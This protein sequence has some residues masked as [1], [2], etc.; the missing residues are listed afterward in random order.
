MVANLTEKEAIN[1]INSLEGKKLDFDGWYGYQCFDLAN[2][3]FNKLF[4]GRLAGF[5]AKNIPTANDFSGKAVVYNNTE[6]FV[7]KPGDIVVFNGNYGGGHG[8]VAIVTNGNADGNLINFVSLDQNWE[9]GGWTSG[10]EQG[11]TG[12]EPA[13]KVTHAYD[14]PMWFIRPKFKA[15]SKSSTQS[16]SKSKSSSN[17][18]TSTTKKKAQTI[19]QSSKRINYTMANRGYKPKAVVI[20]NDAGGS[21]AQQYENSL[22]NA[23]TNRYNAGIAHAYASKG[24]VWEGISEDKIAYHTGDGINKGTGNHEAYGIEVCQSMSASDKAFLQNEQVVFQFI[25]KKMKAWGMKP[26][27]N[28]VKL[29]MEYVPTACPHRSMKLHGGWDPE[30]QGKPSQA[31][32]NKVKDYFIKQIRAYIDGKVPSSTITNNNPSSS[33]STS[34]AAG[35][36][37]KNSYG[38][39]YMSEKARF[40][41]GNQ[42]IVARTTGPFRSCPFAYNF[43]AGGYVDYDEV[44]LQDGHVWIGYD[45]Q[46][47]RYYLP[48]RTWNGVA[49]P[50]H[51]VGS[52]WGVIK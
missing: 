44:M 45:Y 49:P 51:G 23:S 17:K 25:A 31:V 50:N 1:Y 11:G 29:H 24:Y 30:K 14:F 19:K 35:K 12:W 10:P 16:P 27:R 48:I 26:T 47:K 40:V 22:V 41:N 9:G 46:G 15:E 3:Y 21:T 42:S 7:A 38:T 43:Q 32:I 36:W 13:T 2:T 4:G 8:H 33:N 28:T 52:L 18:S 5:S 37:S 6:S 34:T 20:H 39:Y